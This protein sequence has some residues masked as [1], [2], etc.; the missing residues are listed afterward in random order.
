M[1]GIGQLRRSGW[2]DSISS[3]IEGQPICVGYPGA[4]ADQA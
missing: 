1:E 3:I 4:R 2:S